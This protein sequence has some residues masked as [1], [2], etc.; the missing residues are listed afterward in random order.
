MKTVA[1][2]QAQVELD[3][4]AFAVPAGS[5]AASV[6]VTQSYIPTVTQE[7][8]IS[9]MIIS[10]SVADICLLGLQVSY[11]ILTFH[12]VK[13]YCVNQLCACCNI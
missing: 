1:D 7:K 10:H 13:V 11:I 6:S 4:A 3:G 5:S 9:D 2:H 12:I 8:L